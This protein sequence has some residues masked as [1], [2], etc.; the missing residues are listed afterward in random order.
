MNFSQRFTMWTSFRHEV[1]AQVGEQLIPVPFNLNT[2]H[3][4]FEKDK[5]EELE[6]KLTD[7]YGY[8][9]KV[10]IME[11]RKSEDAGIREIADYVY[12]NIFL[13]Y[14]MKQWGQKPEEISEEVTGRVPVLIS[15][16]NGY[17]TDRYQGVQAGIPPDVPKS[18]R[19]SEYYDRVRYRCKK[20]FLKFQED[21]ILLHGET[22]SGVR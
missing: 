1:V 14:T 3:M 20:R 2:L 19:P 4:V 12:Q 10:P 11:L 13:Y 8:G 7:T 6:K 18:V 15:R 21:E 22:I 16:D 9:S 5:A 17:F